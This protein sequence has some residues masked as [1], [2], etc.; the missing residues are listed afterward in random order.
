M[1]PKTEDLIAELKNWCNAEHG[2]RAELSR[3]LNVRPNT[4]SYWLKGEHKPG[5]EETLAIIEFLK[6]P[7]TFRKPGRGLK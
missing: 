4:I 5:S 7:E 3:I 2:R 1:S 6:D